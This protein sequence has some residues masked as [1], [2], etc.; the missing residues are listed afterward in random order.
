MAQK[1]RKLVGVRELRQ[2]LSVYLDRVKEGET[3][4]VTEFGQVVAILAPLPAQK[5]SPLEQ[6]VREGR[7]IAPV[8]SLKDR[9]PLQTAPVGSPTT[10]AMLSDDRVDRL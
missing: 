9:R 5:L 4:R 8:G 3:L 2:N 6:M 1:H 10:E 7:A